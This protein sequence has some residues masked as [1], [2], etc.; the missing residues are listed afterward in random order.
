MIRYAPSNTMFIFDFPSGDTLTQG[1]LFYEHHHFKPILNMHFMLH[2]Y[3]MV[4][5]K[6]F[7]NLLLSAGSHFISKQTS[8]YVFL[9]DYNRFSEPT[10]EDYEL[11]FNNQ[12]EISDEDLP[13][14][15]MLNALQYKQVVYFYKTTIKEDVQP[16][17]EY[18]K[19][20]HFL[21]EMLCV[22]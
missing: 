16:Y 22:M 20:H 8:G 19:Q 13:D 6:E 18:L 9:L 3:G 10:E 17:F 12:Y 2:P 11:R 5:S 7:I 21:V 14:V 4:G 15:E 1:V